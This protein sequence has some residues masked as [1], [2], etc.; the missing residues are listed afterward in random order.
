MVEGIGVNVRVT[1]AVG[2]AYYQLI[3]AGVETVSIK[4]LSKH[5]KDLLAHIVNF[6]QIFLTRQNDFEI[7]EKLLETIREINQQL[8]VKT[9][10]ILS[11]EEEAQ[12]IIKGIAHLGCLSK[13]REECD[14]RLDI[15]FSSQ[16]PT[17]LNGD[18]LVASKR[19]NNKRLVL[20]GDST[21]HGAPATVGIALIGD[22]FYQMVAKEN[23]IVEI[24]TEMNSKLS[25]LIKGKPIAAGFMEI[26]MDNQSV[27]IL[28][29]GLP[30]FI[31][32][33]ETGVVSRVKSLALPLGSA[34]SLPPQISDLKNISFADGNWLIAFT[35]GLIEQLNNEGEMFGEDKLLEIVQST[36]TEY[37]GLEQEVTAEMLAL[38]INQSWEFHRSKVDQGDDTSFIIIHNVTTPK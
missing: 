34:S 3:L 35:D 4:P 25:R 23:S 33:T 37:I 38:R 5:Q 32:I 7:L 15:A 28:H 12:S 17:P 31:H 2:K 26:D 19:Q 18:M 11:L 8:K 27:N 13:S 30:K 16:S 10:E 36:L 20:I 22:I 9:G 24:A 6:M 29:A 14:S 21:G 1:F